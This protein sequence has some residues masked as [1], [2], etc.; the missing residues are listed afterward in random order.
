[1]WGY[2]LNHAHTGHVLGSGTGGVEDR[3][4]P[5]YPGSVANAFYLLY[6]LM[7]L[8]VLSNRL[9]AELALVGVV[10]AAGMLVWA[11]WRGRARK[12]AAGA[13]AVA[14]PFLAP[15]LVVGGAGALAFAARAWGFPI[16]GPGGILPPLEENLNETYTR[17]SNEDYSAFGP[18]GIVALLAASVLAV[19]AYAR[20]RADVRH[21]A[22]ACAFPSFLLLISLGTSWNPF[23]IRFFA[24]PA[25]LG[26]PLLARL[27]R[28]P[29]TAAAYLV[30]ASL[31]VGLTVTHDQTKP[32]TSPYGLGRP[33][34]LDQSNALTTN[35]R[36]DFAVSILAYDRTVPPDA[37]VGAALDDYD[38]SYLLFGPRLQH[39]VV[40]LPTTD[41]V[42]AAVASHVGFVVI[43]APNF[44]SLGDQF[45]A[46][47]WRVRPLG[48]AWLLASAPNAGGGAC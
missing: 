37:C 9:I 14:L 41:P 15:L 36:T 45:R 29:A 42:P 18:I 27:F 47:G 8:S 25:V 48:S 4:S 13:A 31:A 21:L 28:G 19:I 16:R 24:V 26:A 40:Y 46:A 12:T 33:W 38:P 35:S 23:L 11:V 7:D 34:N 22:L 6:G 30:V 44:G 20:R 43:N 39:R 32:L 3:A 1:M 17:F 5:S 10:V 2:V